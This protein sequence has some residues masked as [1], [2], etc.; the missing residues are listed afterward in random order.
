[1]P[2]KRPITEKNAEIIEKQLKESYSEVL[3]TR[4]ILNAYYKMSEDPMKDIETIVRLHKRL[5]SDL[6]TRIES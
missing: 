6:R 5:S 3:K 4:S 1:M 2:Q